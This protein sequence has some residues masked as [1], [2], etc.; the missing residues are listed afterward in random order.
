MDGSEDLIRSFFGV[1]VSFS[2]RDLNP[3]MILS[4]SRRLGSNEYSPSIFARFGGGLLDLASN[5]ANL[6]ALALVEDGGDADRS[7]NE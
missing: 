6:P 1:S 2:G 5:A 3:S 4:L 7:S